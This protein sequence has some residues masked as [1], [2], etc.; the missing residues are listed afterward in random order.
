MAQDN[1]PN[2]ILIM[3]DQQRYDTIGA[4][5]FDWMQ[6]PH[7]DRLVHGGVSFDQCHCT[8]AVCVPSRASFFSM[9]Y[10]HV[11]DSFG[12]GSPWQTCWVEDFQKAGYH[13][14]NVGKMHTIPMDGPFG[15]DERYVV[16]NKDRPPTAH[17]PH[18][19]YLDDWD[20]HLLFSGVRKPSRAT[21]KA[22]HPGWAEGLGAFVWP[23]E[24]H[25]HPDVFV[26]NMAEQV[27]NRRESE[28]PL[29]L[30][31][32]FPGPH[33]P[34]DPPQCDLDLYANVDMPVPALTDEEYAGQPPY[35]A[36]QR[37]NMIDGNHDA[38]R[39][40][41]RPSRE[42]LLRLRR[43]YA[44]NMTTIDRQV[45]RIMDALEQKGYLD[46]AIV[47]FMS[48]HGD[49]LGDHGHIQKWTMYD[50]VTRV[51]AIVYAPGRLEGGKR[52]WDLI[53]H[54][55]LAPLLF[56][57]AG[58][59]VPD[60][61]GAIS[62]LDVALGKRAGR[63]AVFCELLT[64]GRNHFLT[65]ARTQ[66]HKLVHYLDESVGEFYCLQE[67]ADEVHNRWQDVACENDKNALLA[68]LLN[69][70]LTQGVGSVLER[71]VS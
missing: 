22:E 58:V 29:F 60:H 48:D 54:M 18:G 9:E 52:V 2:V 31:I 17:L 4:L 47:V 65:M 11:V 43:Y 46:N 20:R 28:S 21:Y 66:D 69:W 5:G 49:C 63:E 62:A 14:I 55:D 13:T 61:A 67:D 32:G 34:Y 50:C 23:L 7:L 26:G 16:E 53:Q 44:A 38:V 41:E 45:G 39:W 25:L 24:D 6:T 40:H 1:R 57:L 3:T 71:N 30:Q 19:G 33:P 68:H 42:Q 51:P 15:F 35:H 27:I 37:A 8:A 10:P 64:W 36:E 12:N 59:P 70:Q 56:E